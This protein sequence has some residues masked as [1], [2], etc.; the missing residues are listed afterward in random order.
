MAC[1]KW[2]NKAVT[3]TKKGDPR[4]QDLPKD[5]GWTR[6]SAGIFEAPDNDRN[7]KDD[8]KD[9]EGKKDKNRQ[10]TVMWTRGRKKNSS[11]TTEQ[12]R[13]KE[14]YNKAAFA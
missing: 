5:Y 14:F 10:N 8:T 1:A 4:E 11:Q 3:W 9:K 6:H 12:T 7:I 2:I 13:G